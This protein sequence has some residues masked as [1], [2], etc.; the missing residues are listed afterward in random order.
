MSVATSPFSLHPPC[1]IHS[2]LFALPRGLCI[3][4]FLCLEILP[5]LTSHITMR[6]SCSSPF[7][8]CSNVSLSEGLFPATMF[9][10]KT[11]V[12]CAPFSPLLHIVFMHNP[13][14]S[15]ICYIVVIYLFNG[16]CDFHD[17]YPV[18]QGSVSVVF[19]AVPPEPRTMLAYGKV[20]INIFLISEYP[21]KW[22]I[23]SIS[24]RR[25]CIYCND[26]AIAQKKFILSKGSQL[27]G[28]LQ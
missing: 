28:Y 20:S 2:G 26:I 16:R 22:I 9:E 18:R 12:L 11:L 14:L 19:I 1:L 13:T 6:F 23:Q 21:I 7:G 10:I 3:C 27:G 25:W 5:S 17:T 15:G 24:L 4:F 8:L